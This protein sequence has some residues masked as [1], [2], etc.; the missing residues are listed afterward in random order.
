MG[1]QRKGKFATAAVRKFSARANENVINEYQ[2][3]P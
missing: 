2:K 1:L 3:T